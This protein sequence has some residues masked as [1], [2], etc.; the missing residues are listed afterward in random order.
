MSLLFSRSAITKVQVI[1]IA[2]III[3]A[4]AIAGIAYWWTT[5]PA[6]A[7]KISVLAW[8]DSFTEAVK[9]MVPEF[10]ELTGIDVTYETVGWEVVYEKM[11]TELAGGTGAYDIMTLGQD[12]A[13]EWV[14][15]GWFTN[16]T[17]L[18]EENPELLDPEF[19]YP[20]DFIEP[21][22][23]A[24]TIP[25]EPGVWAIPSLVSS[26]FMAY[27]TD[28]FAA[29]NL[30][31]P[32]TW[33]SFIAALKEFVKPEWRGQGIYAYTSP[34]LKGYE[35]CEEW[36]GWVHSFGGDYFKGLWTDP[37]VPW[38]NTPVGREAL[39]F[40]KTLV[41]KKYAVPGTE[42]A[43]YWEA[44]VPYLEGK[45]AMLNNYVDLGLLEVFGD[46]AYADIFENT[47]YVVPPPRG[48]DGRYG[49]MFY[50]YGFA[51][52]SA[53]RNKEDAWEF[54]QWS[55][56]KENMKEL[57]ASGCVARTSVLEDPEVIATYPWMSTALDNLE[58]TSAIWPK[59]LALE[60]WTETLMRE[61]SSGLVGEKTVVGAMNA[62]QKGACDI[63]WGVGEI[64]LKEHDR[65]YEG[66]TEEDGEPRLGLLTGINGT[67]PDGYRE[68]EAVL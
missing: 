33:D 54:I 22:L 58:K 37:S 40:M 52:T 13:L 66:W 17:A 47:G 41:D 44:A 36:Y 43:G 12:W 62:L 50:L 67:L 35:I 64:T 11:V 38:H 21:I 39:D 3:M 20:D 68:W 65:A 30:S 19:D 51:I 1:T 25:G 49:G 57:V 14:K 61:L 63:L 60:P 31:A 10:E 53:S 9:G 48:D 7:K 23:E 15:N 27:R 34:M 45:A 28:W 59:I 26:R 4:A 2:A 24:L 29:K 5:R 16:L 18:W 6:P 32:D 46:P 56:S 55:H 42:G 8:S